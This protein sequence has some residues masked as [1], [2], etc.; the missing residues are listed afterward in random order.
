MPLVVDQEQLRNWLIEEIRPI[1]DADPN[2]LAK[3]VVALVRKDK[4]EAQLKAFC[5]EQL[6]VFL[7]AKS[8]SFVDH[9]FDV[10]NRDAY[11]TKPPAPAAAPAAA[12]APVA[13]PPA[14][15]SSPQQ[16]LHELHRSKQKQSPCPRNSRRLSAKSSYLQFVKHRQQ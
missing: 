8:A 2:A 15:S 16:L 11:K 1:C 13:A 4:P 14:A 6:E 12:P 3:Y 5:V 7:Q 10:I 9:L